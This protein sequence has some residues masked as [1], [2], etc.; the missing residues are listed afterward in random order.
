MTLMNPPGID[1]RAGNSDS[2]W[3]LLTRHCDTLLGGLNCSSVLRRTAPPEKDIRD[4]ATF[5]LDAAVD[6]PV[7]DRR[8][9][10]HADDD[11]D[12]GLG[13]Q[14][15]VGDSS[16]VS[17][18]SAILTAPEAIWEPSLGIYLIAKGLRPDARL[19]ARD[20]RDTGADDLAFRPGESAAPARAQPAGA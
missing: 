6:L 1:V 5:V 16:S 19:L 12:I 9:V 18:P 7:L 17:G 14:P 3:F 8:E 11:V 20:R 10:E 13:R 2:G 15:A 4:P